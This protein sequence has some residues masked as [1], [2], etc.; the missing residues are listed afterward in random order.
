MHRPGGRASRAELALLVAL[1]AW[2]LFPVVLLV[3]HAVNTHARF[4]GADGLIGWD[5]VLGADQLQYLAW[6]RDAGAH[7]LASD[8]FTLAPSGHV[9]LEPIFTITGA[10]WRLG[11]SLPLAYLL[12][13]PVA[14]LVL[15]AATLAWARRLCGERLRARAAVVA[16]SLFLYTPLAELVSWTKLG[17][18]TF[19]FQMSLL[20]SELLSAAGLW[21]YIPGLLAMAMVPVALLAVER[22]LGPP[23]GGP[24]GRLA[25]S[26]GPPRGPLALASLA[27]LLASWLHPWQGATLLVIFAGLAVWQRLRGWR[28]LALPAIA[29]GLPIVYYYV[30]SH[31]DSAWRLAAHNEIASRFSPLVLL[32]GLGPVALIAIA[33]VRRPGPVII[34]RALLLW[35]AAG[36]VTYFA[37][38]TFAPDAFQG[39][40]LPLAVL[41]VRG[42]RRLS[43]PA[44]LGALAIVVVTL[45][46]LANDVRRFIAVAGT[47]RTQYY[48]TGSDAKA[49]DW[50]A[51]R[52]P[53]G[54]VLAPT[55]FAAVVPSET[56]RAVWVGH[57]FWSPDY[58]ARARATDA[59]FGGRM[60]RAPARAFV[61]QSGASVLIADCRHRA[62][63]IPALRVILT[64]VHRFGCARVYIVDRG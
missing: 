45:P 40:G 3:V 11:V 7:G 37:N 5:G 30:L 8:L 51:D 52:A 41:A 63:L 47:S 23:L 42:W 53:P 36:F 4:T 26:V 55:P 21:G 38:S 56:G 59:L 58:P 9:L 28:T 16:L 27:A 49:L 44:V 62:N 17:S 46:G 43:L 12:W 25:A 24:G 15:F 10:L 48:L 34:E 14:V 13:K 1:A 29:A 39:L 54:G 22:A 35:I 6:A 20:G 60:R 50:V 33:G 61:L 31:S 57:G 2:G 18:G 19:R 32:A 64:A